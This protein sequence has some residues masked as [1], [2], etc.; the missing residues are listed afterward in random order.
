MPPILIPA[1]PASQFNVQGGTV[2]AGAEGYDDRSWKPEALW[3]PRLSFG[4]RLGDKMAIK[5][6][7]GMYYDTLNAR[8]WTPDLQGFNVTTTNPLSNDFGRTFALGDPRNGILPLV[9]PFP[10]RAATG[11]RYENVLGNA[12]GLDTM[13]GRGSRR[14]TRTASTRACS[15]GVCPGSGRSPAARRSRSRTPGRTPTGRAVTIRQDYLPEQYWNSANFRD[16]SANDFLTAERPEPVQHRELRL[17]PDD[18]PAALSA[19]A[20]VAVFTRRP[21][22]SA[23]AC[24]GRSRT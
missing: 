1:L 19:A 2:Y 21:R 11:S 6:G 16:T 15:G 20:G 5:G 23:T 17:A 13:L 14:R 4:Y 9:D 8:D 22:S 10:V 24:C 7:Y 12:L 18:Q 3:M